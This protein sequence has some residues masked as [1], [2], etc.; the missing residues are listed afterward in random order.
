M[1][2]TK[3]ARA[4]GDANVPAPIK[5]LVLVG[6]GNAHLHVL[7]EW[8][9]RP[10]PNVELVV[11]SPTARQWNSAMM[12]GYL[13]GRYEMSDIC[14]D[15]TELARRAGA[16]LV[17]TAVD[18]VSVAEHVV[19]CARERIPFDLCSVDVSCELS[20]G[21]IPGMRE[22]AAM[23]QPVE[24]A[25]RLRNQLDSLLADGRA[26]LSVAIIGGGTAGVE[27]AF[28]MAARLRKSEGSGQVTIV[29]GA[30]EVLA[31]ES[32]RLK[33][34]AAELLRE[35][36][37]GL[38]LGGRVTSIATD[39]LTLASGAV[40]PANLI[41]RATGAAPPALLVK[42]DLPRDEAGYLLVDRKLRAIGNLPVW[43]AGECVTVSKHAR[44]SRSGVHGAHDGPGLLR[45]LRAA[46]G[47]GRAARAHPHAASLM[48]LSTADGRALVR[49]GRFH[50]YARWAS[51]LKERRNRKFVARF[52]AGCDE[53]AVPRS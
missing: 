50:D 35:R 37:I 2:D 7:H 42:S 48:L 47:V 30:R 49:R 24:Q 1:T 45:N 32:E 9:R 22:H 28:A 12:S 17:V 14:I 33:H 18:R 11:I 6:A 52:G 20:G 34:R 40:V 43:G 41:V 13:E 31:G 3:P 5:R 27:A 25:I 44:T 29:D 19:V 46:L 10:V 23:L 36:G 4:E 38:V 26:P 8:S 53:K 21:E 15:L 39:G 51:W 16:R